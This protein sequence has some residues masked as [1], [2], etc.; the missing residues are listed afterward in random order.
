MLTEY[1]GFSTEGNSLKTCNFTRLVILVLLPV[2]P[3]SESNGYILHC[4]PKGHL[5]TYVFST[6][7]VFKKQEVYKTLSCFL[8][9]FVQILFWRSQTSYFDI[10][11]KHHSYEVTKNSIQSILWT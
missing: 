7:E 10:K 11:Y 9:V 4:W 2:R 8:T 6:Y 1:V 5:V 3:N